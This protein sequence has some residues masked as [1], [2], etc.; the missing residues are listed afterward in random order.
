MHTK[1][2]LSLSLPVTVRTD[3][4]ALFGE[5][6]FTT[7]RIGASVTKLRAEGETVRRWEMDIADSRMRINR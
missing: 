4:L 2:L 1:L 3:S 7:S 5:A 6:P